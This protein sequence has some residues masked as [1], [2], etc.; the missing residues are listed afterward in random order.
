MVL[1]FRDLSPA[2]ARGYLAEA[3]T[4]DLTSALGRFPALFV[5]ARSSAYTYAGR[6]GADRDD[7]SR[8]RRTLRGRG[9]RARGRR[10][11]RGDEP[12]RRRRDRARTCGANASSWVS[13]RPTRSRAQL[14]EQVV[15]ALGVR[16]AEAELERLRHRP[17]EDLDAYELS[18]QA[19]ADFFAYTR[20]SHARARELLERAL[21]LDPDYPLAVTYRAAARAGAVLPRLG[22]GPGADR[23]RAGVRGARA[24]ARS[25]RR[26]CL[27]PRSRMAN[28]AEGRAEEAVEEARRAVELGPSSDICLGVQA[29]ALAYSGRPLDALR[30]A[31]PGAAPEPAPPRALLADG[32]PAPGA[33]G[34]PRPRPPAARAGARGEP[35]DG[36]RR[37]SR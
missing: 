29:A 8:A 26:R 33:G 20:E 19:R 25:V 27:T 15:A 7:Q 30:L 23:T 2:G 37:A 21:A 16:I 36:A 6:D 28:I 4:E 9:Q 31:R 18:V 12:A 35:R 32:G 11:A 17:T 24:R 14:A 13:T 34:A 22:R 3:I 1:P 5:I 10:G